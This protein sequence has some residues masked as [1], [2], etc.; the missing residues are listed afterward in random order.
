MKLV[1]AFKGIVLKGKLTLDNPTRFKTLI[2]IFE[3]KKV[4]IS[5]GEVKKPRSNQANKYYW[6]C[7]VGIP[8]EY[9]G[10]FPEEMHS[11]FKMM[12]LKKHNEG[13]P[14]TTRSTT[15]LST[16]EFSEYVERCKQFCAEQG[17]VIPDA[18]SVSLD[19]PD[20]KLE[21]DPKY[22]NSR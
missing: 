2:P 5:V 15:D 3:G 4:Q 18:D 13:K 16:S 7:V 10:Y 17:I 12:F 22:S 19:D 9:F 21:I 6:S 1:H 20:F 14:D 8:A 11:A